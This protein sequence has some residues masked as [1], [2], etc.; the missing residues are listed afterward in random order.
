MD[1]EFRRY[2]FSG[3]NIEDAVL[4]TEK[5]SY[6]AAIESGHKDTYAPEAWED[7]ASD[8]TGEASAPRRGRP[9]KSKE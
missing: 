6:D 5:A 7:E 4:H 3:P 9:P 2:S 8:S 1:S